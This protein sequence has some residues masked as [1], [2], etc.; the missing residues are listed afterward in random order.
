MKTS[1]SSIVKKFAILGFI[2]GEA[3][4]FFT[5]AS[6]RLK[7]VDIPALSIAIRV[8]ALSLLFGPFGL[9]LGTGVGLLVDGLYRSLRPADASKTQPTAAP[10]EPE[11]L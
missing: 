5:V 9:A 10:Q 2:F 1:G 7:G 11:R 4:M 3:Y 6:P 8:A